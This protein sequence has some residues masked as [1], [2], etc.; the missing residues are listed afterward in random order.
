MPKKPCLLCHGKNPESCLICG[1]KIQRIHAKKAEDHKTTGYRERIGF[2]LQMDIHLDKVDVNH[3]S[4]EIMGH[5]G[6]VMQP[7]PVANEKIMKE[8]EAFRL[9]AKELYCSHCEQ[10]ESIKNI[11]KREN[12]NPA[13]CRRIIEQTR[14]K[15][16]RKGAPNVKAFIKG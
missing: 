3:I 11:A 2:Y 15:L 8:L 6:V 7:D 16:I 9:F 5:D 4:T 1:F 14:R 10:G 12:L 13:L